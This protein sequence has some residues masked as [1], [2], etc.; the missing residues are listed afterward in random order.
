MTAARRELHP[1]RLL[2]LLLLACRHPPPPVLA[3]VFSLLL[4]VWIYPPPLHLPVRSNLHRP[5]P[6]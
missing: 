3:L 4:R 1:Y 6:P 5:P 2:L